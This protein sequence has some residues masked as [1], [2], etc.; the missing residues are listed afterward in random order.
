MSTAVDTTFAEVFVVSDGTGETA[1]GAVRAAMSQ[2]QTSWRLRT[3]GDVRHESQVRRVVQLA[4]RS[5]AL[6]VFTVVDK[7]VA[8]KIRNL[9]GELGVPVVDVLGPLIS[10][11]AQHLH[12]E[13]KLKPGL[14]H[15]FSD[16][17]FRRIEAVE[18]AVRHDDGMNMHTLFEADLVLTGPSRTSKTPLSMYLAQ[19]GYKI[20][21][22]PLIPTIEPSRELCEMDP[23][24]VLGLLLDPA[25][26]LTVRQ[27]RM[28]TMGAPPYSAYVDREGVAQEIERARRVFRSRGW[29]I[30]DTTGRAVEETASRVLELLGVDSV[31]TG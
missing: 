3:F 26:L 12:V 11:V 25:S 30:V 22:V 29:R 2:F 21:N 13:P 8:E 7:R 23:R 16:Q 24:K 27:A 28:R 9:S 18:F 6:V 14:L 5:G 31:S 10:N 19:R 1:T 20:G 17:Y 15:G 4:Q